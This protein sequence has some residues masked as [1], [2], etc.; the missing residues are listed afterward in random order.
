MKMPPQLSVLALVLLLY[1]WP[2]QLFSGDEPVYWLAS[3]LVMQLIFVMACNKM[4]SE[5]WASLVIR[6]ETL[7][8]FINSV[9]L[10][11]TAKS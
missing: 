6:V 10:M 7:C 9:L 11:I 4:S 1:F 2:W 8:M 3:V 5:Y